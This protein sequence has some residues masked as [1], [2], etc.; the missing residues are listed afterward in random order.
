M[1]VRY[2]GGT[3][4]KCN[5]STGDIQFTTNKREK[6]KNKRKKNIKYKAI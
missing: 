1:A 2:L 6:I 3:F 5:N 4:S